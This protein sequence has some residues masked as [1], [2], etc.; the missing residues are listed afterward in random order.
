MLDDM[1]EQAPETHPLLGC[2]APH[3]GFVYSGRVAGRLFGHL[4]IPRRVI[5]LG[6][7]H[8]GGGDPVSVAPHSAWETPFGD[9]PVDAELAETLVQRHGGAS[10][11]TR[12]HWREHSI[13]VQLPFLKRLQ[14][15]VLVTPVC[16]KHLSQSD[17]LELADTLAS[18]VTGI[19]EPVGLVASSDM[20]HYEPDPEARRRDQEAIDAALSV[21]PSRL[22]E[23]V[24]RRRISM[25]GVVPATVVLAAAVKLGANAG[26]L[27][28]YAT[29]G[30]VSRDLTSVVGYA[31]ICFHRV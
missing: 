24:H 22:Y 4:E 12:A 1:I 2:I 3:A 30:D 26:H 17:C 5:V 10:F 7:N 27:V 15:E 11:D 19:D 21:D 20:T 18:I 23:T 13:E 31:G 29:S 25:C 28:D 8:T 16:V 9:V 14:P 6:P